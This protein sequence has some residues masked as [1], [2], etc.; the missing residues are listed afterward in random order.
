MTGQD[1]P[2]TTLIFALSLTGFVLFWAAL[3][4]IKADALVLPSPFVVAETLWAEAA[5]GRLWRHLGATLARLAAAFAIAMALGVALGLWLGQHAKAD[6]WARPWVTI[7]LNMPALVLIVLCYLWIG[8]NEGALVA[9]VAINKTAMVTVTLREG[10]RM[11]APG[12]AD[13]ARVYGLRRMA[14]LVHVQLPQLMPYLLAAARSGIAMIWKVVLVAEFLGRSSGV[15]FQ[16][17][18]NFQLFNI[19]GVLAYALA[20]VALMLAIE[21]GVFGALERR[22]FRWKAA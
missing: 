6:L 3:S 13:L 14:V 19:A 20:F 7:F 12:L 5:S 15:G 10:T 2:R 9:A 17:H 1:T 4:A 8:L 11:M 18:L 16:I 22:A 21:Y